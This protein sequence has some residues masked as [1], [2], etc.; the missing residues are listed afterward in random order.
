M[1]MMEL[2][3][4]VMAQMASGARFVKGTITI[5]DSG[6]FYEI[7]I[8]K[9]FN[10]Y[11]VYIEATEESKTQIIN[12]TD[13]NSKSWALFEVYPRPKING[14]TFGFL[15]GRYNPISQ[16]IN[17]GA[18]TGGSVTSTVVQISIG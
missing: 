12:N 2:R 16:A 18:G 3:R 8:G 17:A 5:P 6:S 9:T 11:I 13:N 15:T 1:D 7:N 14:K 10:K 4:M